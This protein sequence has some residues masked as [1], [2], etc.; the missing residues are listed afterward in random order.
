MRTVLIAHR[1][2][3][4]AS[5]LATPLLQAGYRTITCPGPWPPALRCIRCDV[6]YCPLTEAADV[7][8]YDPNLVGYDGQGSAHALAVDSA[9]AHPDVPL[10]LA[11]PEAEEPTA[12]ETIA[13]QV[14]RVQRASREA[15]ALVEQVW[16][17]VG[18][19]FAQS[20]VVRPGKPAG[21][22]RATDV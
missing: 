1:D 10:L 18:P 9:Q 22:D 8:I 2:A 5:S 20:T 11:W 12:T 21:T 19:P 15:G 4:F 17:L 13:S 6:G 7:L 16:S 3:S 14:A